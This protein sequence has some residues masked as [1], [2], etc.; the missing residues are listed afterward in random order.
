M[1]RK[2]GELITILNKPT[3]D[4]VDS[5]KAAPAKVVPSTPTT[6]TPVVSTSTAVAPSGARNP[7]AIQL[8]SFFFLDTIQRL[9]KAST[10][11]DLSYGGLRGDFGD[12][13][14]RMDERVP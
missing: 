9:F 10:A 12:G 13:L 2:S 6:V 11:V 3:T 5:P 8:V 1:S 14:S 7:L 4:K